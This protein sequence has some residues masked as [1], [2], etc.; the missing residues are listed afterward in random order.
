MKKIF[1]KLSGIILCFLMLFSIAF[2]DTAKKQEKSEIEGSGYYYENS[3]TY[4]NDLIVSSEEIPS[5]Y[6][7]ADFYPMVNENQKESS[8]CWIY[9]SAKS[10]ETAFMVQRNEFYNFSETGLAYLSYADNADKFGAYASFNV[11]GNFSDF[12]EFYQDY[13]L[14]L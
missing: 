11:G 4:L 8:F 2:I 6:N 13:G 10:L 3:E 12:V 9:A 5:K 7:L 14:V 1:K